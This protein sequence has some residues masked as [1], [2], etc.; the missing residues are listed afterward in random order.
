MSYFSGKTSYVFKNV[1]G[2]SCNVD[3]IYLAGPMKMKSH[4]YLLRS[5]WLTKER[6]NRNSNLFILIIQL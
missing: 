4:I 3:V 6:I 1:Y 5:V 2:Y